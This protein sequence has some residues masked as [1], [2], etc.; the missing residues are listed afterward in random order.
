M[1]ASGRLKLY[2][3]ATI[4][5]EVDER[6][7]CHKTLLLGVLTTL[8]LKLL[9]LGVKMPPYLRYLFAFKI[10]WNASVFNPE[11]VMTILGIFMSLL[12]TLAIIFKYDSLKLSLPYLFTLLFVFAALGLFFMFLALMFTRSD[13]KQFAEVL[14][15]SNISLTEALKYASYESHRLIEY[16]TKRKSA[17]GK[18]EALLKMTNTLKICDELKT[19]LAKRMSISERAFSEDVLGFTPSVFINRQIKLADLMPLLDTN[20]RAKV[21]AESIKDYADRTLRHL[22][23]IKKMKVD[24]DKFVF[25]FQTRSITGA[26]QLLIRFLDKETRT[27]KF[28]ET[29]HA[30]L[31]IQNAHRTGA[32]SHRAISLAMCELLNSQKTLDDYR[33]CELRISALSEKMLQREKHRRKDK[34]R[35][36]KLIEEQKGSFLN[37]HDDSYEMIKKHREE[38]LENF[39]NR[40]EQINF[41]DKKTGELLFN[42]EDGKLYI[43]VSAYS[44]VV[45][46]VIQDFFG[47]AKF[48]DKIRIVVCTEDVL[49]GDFSTRTMYHQICYESIIGKDKGVPLS[50][51]KTF[52]HKVSWRSSVDELK[53]RFNSQRD[54]MIYLCGCDHFRIANSAIKGEKSKKHYVAYKYSP[55][56]DLEKIKEF[57]LEVQCFVFGGDH[58]YS[59]NSLAALVK[60]ME[61]D[62]KTKDMEEIAKT[63]EGYLPKIR[64]S[65]L[66]KWKSFEDGRVSMNMITTNSPYVQ[67]DNLQGGLSSE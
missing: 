32:A 19:I 33:K 67:C 43:V 34:L 26:M 36:L 54:K 45:N 9:N 59:M 52:F 61:H 3:K 44:Q 64:R 24:I 12:G 57:A 21:K 60:N 39:E 27:L 4:V 62:N 53:S 14:A 25:I 28:P 8:S 63:I 22:K 6:N 10:I 58:K 23:A 56:N 18:L 17:E 30:L 41:L 42:E 38:M 51:R 2:I 37:W 7:Y 11:R 20:P 16:I 65:G 48:L 47:K 1:S 5:L 49:E 29:L 66:H 50:E 35:Q 40:M 15:A 46:K 55:S 13:A 31:K